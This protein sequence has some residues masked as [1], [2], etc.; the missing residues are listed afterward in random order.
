MKT[1]NKC[2]EALP[3]S[4]FHRD[5]HQADGHTT[6]CKSCR[7]RQAAAWNKAH[8]DRARASVKA[9]R[10]RH[11]EKAK[12]RGRRTNVES[13]GITMADYEDMLAAQGNACAICETSFGDATPHVDHNHESGR[14]RALLCLHCN[15]GIGHL[16]DSAILLQRAAEYI[17]V[18]DHLDALNKI[19]FND[20]AQV[21]E[22]TASKL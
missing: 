5:R 20:D 17:T 11:P 7:S 9:W 2:G 21:K 14:V 13:Y 6:A 22:I 16:K 1:C 4:G 18:H 10:A 12:Q 3:L 19:A 8:P 15:T